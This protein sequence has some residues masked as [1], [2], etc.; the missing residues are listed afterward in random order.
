MF[1][2]TSL[3]VISCYE[4]MIIGKFLSIIWRIIFDNQLSIILSKLE[5]IHEKL[6][7]LN[8]AG[9]MKIKINWLFIIGI[10]VHILA[11]MMI[12]LIWM[13]MHISDAEKIN[14]VIINI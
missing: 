1:E 11:G 14:M 6:I 12:P 8:M 13:Q 10:I 2:V 3:I 5:K 9:P 7:C 4:L